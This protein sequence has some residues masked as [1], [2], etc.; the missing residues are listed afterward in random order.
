MKL[1]NILKMHGNAFKTPILNNVNKL[2]ASLFDKDWEY[3]N[4]FSSGI[5][6]IIHNEQYHTQIARNYLTYDCKPIEYNRAGYVI[7]VQHMFHEYQHIQQ[8]TKEWNTASDMES[9]ANVRRVTDIVRRSFIKDYY[10]SSYTHNYAKDPGE[11][12]AEL[13]GIQQSIR[14]FEHDDIIS[15][16]EAKETLFQ[17][18]MSEDYGHK[19]ELDKYNI[20]SMDDLISAFIDLRNT[21]VH[22]IYPITLES[23]LLFDTV[24]LTDK[25]ITEKFL[26][27]S[28]YQTHRDEVNRCTDGRKLDKLLEQTIVLE[29]PDVIERVPRLR[30]ELAECKKQMES[31]IFI[32]KYY[33]IPVSKINYAGL[34]GQISNS[35]VCLTDEDLSG[36][37]F[38]KENI[39]L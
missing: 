22:D 27:D 25:D 10:G 31:R 23:S 39:E 2:A 21:V 19:L 3:T 37:P 29:Y 38:D 16:N 20:K 33:A 5:I 32:P 9:V 30:K 36:I 8:V 17:L 26:T 4:N 15:Q 12:D 18:M 35:E 11:M 14:Y 24:I 6:P 1:E 7:T 13:Y 34:I 28:K